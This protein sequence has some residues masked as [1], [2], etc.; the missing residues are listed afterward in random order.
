M[1]DFNMYTD[2]VTTR[3]DEENIIQQMDVLFNTRPHDVLGQEEFGTRYDKFLYD[4]TIT[5]EAI[6]N[7]IL[8]D[9]NGLEL[10]GYAPDVDVYLLKGTQNDIL[11]I[12]IHMT[13]ADNEFQKI[14]K[15]V[16]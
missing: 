14:Y 9:V 13:R 3:S 11:M 10:F 8:N 15:I 16:E 5:N 4:L 1:I 12:D 6:R 2:D 7:V